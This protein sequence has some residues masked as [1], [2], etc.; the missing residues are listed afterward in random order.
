MAAFTENNAFSLVGFERMLEHETIGREIIRTLV[1][2]GGSM[3]GASVIGISL[4]WVNARTDIPGRRTLEAL[5]VIP[6][7][8]SAFVGAIAWRLLLVP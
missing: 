3:L 4:A 8:M 7:F 2:A 1:F 5:C 6:L